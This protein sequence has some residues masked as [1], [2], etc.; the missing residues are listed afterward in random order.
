MTRRT[1]EEGPGRSGQ[2]E[3]WGLGR[4]PWLYGEVLRAMRRWDPR[5]YEALIGG[6]NSPWSPM[7]REGIPTRKNILPN[8]TP[9]HRGRRQGE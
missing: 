9:P 6:S 1:P 4:G 5:R 7:K 8:P 2:G 3:P